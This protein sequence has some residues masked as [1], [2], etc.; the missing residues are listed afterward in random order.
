MVALGE[1]AE[2]GV[3]PLQQRALECDGFCGDGVVETPGEKSGG[4][5]GSERQ[6]WNDSSTGGGHVVRVDRYAIGNHRG[7]QPVEKFQFAVAG[8][9]P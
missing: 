6:M 1:I 3:A 9:S 5:D 7:K 4:W 8:V 2:A